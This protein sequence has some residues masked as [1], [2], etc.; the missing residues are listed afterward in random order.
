MTTAYVQFEPTEP[1]AAEGTPES[2]SVHPASVRVG[3]SSGK[4]GCQNSSVL[5]SNRS[6]P[7]AAIAV[8]NS[9]SAAEVLCTLPAWGGPLSSS[10]LGGNWEKRSMVMMGL[11]SGR[12]TSARIRL[13]ISCRNRRRFAASPPYWSVRWLV[14]DQRNWWSR[15]WQ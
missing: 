13:T 12:R 1:P 3:C 7:A 4:A 5:Q 9:P 15:Y 6:T 10:N 2:S 14:V 11:P 8:T